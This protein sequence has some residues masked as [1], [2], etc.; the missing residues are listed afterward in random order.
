MAPN[1]NDVEHGAALP[2]KEVDLKATVKPGD[3]TPLSNPR[4]LGYGFQQIKL[5]AWN[6]EDEDYWK[7]SL[8]YS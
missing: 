6:P 3:A 5:N 1:M 4:S 7:V 2:D 8:C